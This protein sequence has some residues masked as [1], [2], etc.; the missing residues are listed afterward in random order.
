M[1][2]LELN[3]PGSVIILPLSCVI[4]DPSLDLSVPQFPHLKNADDNNSHED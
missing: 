1:W 4:L 2:G 3:C